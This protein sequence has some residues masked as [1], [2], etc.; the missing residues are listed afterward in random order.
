MNAASR[1]CL[2]CRQ[3][4][5]RTADALGAGETYRIHFHCENCGVYEVNTL[6][7]AF[8]VLQHLSDRDPDWKDEDGETI[9]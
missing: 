8:D 4:S 7:G 2:I 1:L 6:S 3:E 9:N 5:A